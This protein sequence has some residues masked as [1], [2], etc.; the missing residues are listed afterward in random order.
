VQCGQDGCPRTF[1]SFKYL[2]YL[3]LHFEKQHSSLINDNDLGSWSDSKRIKLTEVID[4]TDCNADLLHSEQDG[5]LNKPQ[6]AYSGDVEFNFEQPTI[7]NFM[8]SEI[9]NVAFS[10]IET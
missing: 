9:I 7:R 8:N 2:K 6:A 5:N 1:E 3:K 4:S 10:V